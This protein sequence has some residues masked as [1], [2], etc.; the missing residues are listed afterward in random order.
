M[1]TGVLVQ[2]GFKKINEASLREREDDIAAYLYYV[3]QNIISFYCSCRSV[4]AH[5]YYTRAH[6]GLGFIYLFL[7][8]PLKVHD[9]CSGETSRWIM[10]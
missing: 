7:T 9:E 8:F 5:F 3:D 4:M 10:L 6:C 1:F 2:M